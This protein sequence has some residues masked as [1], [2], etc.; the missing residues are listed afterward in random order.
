[1]KN[2]ILKK[3]VDRNFFS[4]IFF[5][6]KSKSKFHFLGFFKFLAKKKSKIRNF[7]FS[8]EIFEISTFSKKNLEKCV[9]FENVF[10]TFLKKFSIFFDDFF[11]Q[12]LVFVKP[13]P[14]RVPVAVERHVVHPGV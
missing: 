8:V 14:F 13:H 7:R 5:R 3:K 11:F 1:M 2:V 6:R 12:D 9:F 10:S 4:T